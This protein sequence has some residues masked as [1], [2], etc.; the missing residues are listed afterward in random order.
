MC[1]YWWYWP[2][3]LVSVLESPLADFL[4]IELTLERNLL[5]II[6]LTVRILV[7]HGDQKWTID[8]IPL[9]QLLW[10]LKLIVH[11][12][13]GTSS[14]ISHTWH[15]PPAMHTRQIGSLIS[16]AQRPATAL[17]HHHLLSL[18]MHILCLSQSQFQNFHNHIFI[19]IQWTSYWQAA[20]NTSF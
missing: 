1:Q 18:S 15:L 9:L 5:C 11:S 16:A 20:I 10:Y 17:R 14:V 4:L 8:N 7:F 19:G 12:Y 13:A 3:F 6:A 2:T